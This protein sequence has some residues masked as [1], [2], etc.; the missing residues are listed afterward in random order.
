M[1][2]LI[3]LIMFHLFVFA[4]IFIALGCWPKKILLQ[5]MSEEFC[6]YSLLRVLWYH[7][8]NIIKSLI[9]FEFIFMYGKRECSNFTDLHAVSNFPHT[10]C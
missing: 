7:V 3:S 5:F 4:F 2:R 9:H 10:T 6:I 1:Q 8:L